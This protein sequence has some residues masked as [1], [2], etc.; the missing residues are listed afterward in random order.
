MGANQQH[1]AGGPQGIRIDKWLWAARFFKT[2]ALAAEAVNGGKVHLN[3]QRIK[4][5]KDVRIGDELRI[6]RGE[7]AFIVTVQALSSQRG[8]AAQAAALYQETEASRVARE[9][10]REQRRL[11]AQTAPVAP[12]RPSKR[13]RR[14]IIRFIRQ[15]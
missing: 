2:R 5:A 15:E 3:G 12:R 13:D 8:P 4:P 7:E 11:M 10:Q 14:H 6:T 1:A 9:A